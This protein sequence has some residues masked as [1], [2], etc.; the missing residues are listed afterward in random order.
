MDKYVCLVQYIS[1]YVCSLCHFKPCRSFWKRFTKVLPKISTARGRFKTLFG[2]GSVGRDCRVLGPEMTQ[3]KKK[4]G[5]TKRDLDS[6][7][8]GGQGRGLSIA[9]AGDWK[10]L[11]VFDVFSYPLWSDHLPSLTIQKTK[12][13]IRYQHH[14]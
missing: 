7:L 11:Y 6:S 5:F 4:R 8:F 1:N 13:R 9:K 3:T 14:L 10:I 12:I 2:T